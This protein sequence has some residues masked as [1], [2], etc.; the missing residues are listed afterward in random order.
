M[1][2]PALAGDYD[3]LD[4]NGV[5]MIFKR[6]GK[7]MVT[8]AVSLSVI[9]LIISGIR[10]MRAGDNPQEALK[11]RKNFIYVLIGIVVIVGFGVIINTVINAVG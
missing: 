10:Y 6:L 9:Y 8:A 3:D 7:F 2:N 11:A 5:V 1:P 4:F